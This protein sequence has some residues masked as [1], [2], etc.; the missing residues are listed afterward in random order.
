MRIKC[1]AVVFLFTAIATST[2]AAGLTM[3]WTIPFNSQSTGLHAQEIQSVNAG[4]N[5]FYE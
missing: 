2:G 4:S 5:V 3:I 1:L